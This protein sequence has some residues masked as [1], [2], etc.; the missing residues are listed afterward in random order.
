MVKVIK[1]S[2]SACMILRKRSGWESLCGGER[3]AEE[4]GS[5]AFKKLRRLSYLQGGG[6]GG[7]KL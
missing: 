6:E 1:P 2:R 3:G 4:T 5:E 7:R